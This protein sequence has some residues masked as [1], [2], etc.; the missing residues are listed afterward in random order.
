MTVPTNPTDRPSSTPTGHRA[1]SVELQRRLRC[2]DWCVVDHRGEFAANEAEGFIVMD[3]VTHEARA[4][5]P[6]ISVMRTDNIDEGRVGKPVLY[7]AV[8]LE[9]TTWEDAGRL[10]HA[11]LDGVD[12]LIGADQD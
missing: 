12:Y 2:P 5:A 11:I 8:E 3:L 6:G 9:I 4:I 7:V 10:A 1:P